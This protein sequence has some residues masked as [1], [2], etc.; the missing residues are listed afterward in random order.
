MTLSVLNGFVRGVRLRDVPP[1][2]ARIFV[3]VRSRARA[4]EAWL[5]A[6]AISVGIASGVAAHI[7]NRTSVFLHETLFGL[8]PPGTLS[9]QVRISS[10]RL[11]LWLPFGGALLGAVTWWWRRKHPNAIVDAV[12]ANALHGGRMSLRDSLFLSLQ[13]LISNGFGASVGLEAAYA[14]LGSGGASALG[15]R[16]NLRRN[17][18]R[19]LV[20]AGAGAAIGA[21]FGA[22]LTGAFY[23]F[24]LIIGSYTV[25]SIA[26]VVGAALAGY[27]AS[28]WMG[29]VPRMVRREGA[30]Q[31]VLERAVA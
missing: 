12:E 8:P 18:L 29:G 16:L 2:L 19:I 27:A 9:G 30:V 13:T 31:R 1:E 5:L 10:W 11:L 7:L 15:V 23:A 3:R 17:D 25:A 4:N 26:P 20:G 28:W 22:P 21:A 6:L 14:Q 24:E